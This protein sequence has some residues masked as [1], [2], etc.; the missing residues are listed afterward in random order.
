MYQVECCGF[1]RTGLH[2]GSGT[3]D[4]TQ[5]AF[6]RTAD[7]HVVV[8]GTSLAG[9]IRTHLT[10]LVPAM[11]ALESDGT[12]IICDALLA[13]PP[14]EDCKCIV[15]HLMGDINPQPIVRAKTGEAAGTRASRLTIS[16]GLVESHKTFV[17]DGVSIDRADGTAARA[18]MA[19]YDQEVLRNAQLC[20]SVSLEDA[21]DLDQMLVRLI[22][23]EMFAGRVYLGGSKGRGLGA[24]TL[25]SAR[26]TQLNLNDPAHLLHFL[27][28]DFPDSPEV[29][30][31]RA[32]GRTHHASYRRIIGASAQP[33]LS[34]S[35]WVRIDVPMKG[36]GFFMTNDQTRANLNGLNHYALPVLPGASIRGVL[37]SHAE[38][39]AR[40]IANQ[41]SADEDDFLSRLPAAYP[42][43]GQ[44]D[45]TADEQRRLVPLESTASRLQRDEGMSEADREAPEYEWFD[46]AERLFGT[47]YFGSRLMVEDAPLTIEAPPKVLDFL[48]VDRFTG[49]GADGAKFDALVYWQPEFTLSLYLE[50]PQPWEI[51]WLLV[52]LRDL[53][54]GRLR[55][56]FGSAKGFGA[57]NVLGTA[58]TLGWTYDA[59]FPIDDLR[60]IPQPHVEGYFYQATYDSFA[61]LPIELR[62]GWNAAWLE[63]VTNFTTTDVFTSAH[64]A[65]DPYW[66]RQSDGPALHEIYGVG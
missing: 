37:R 48:A 16:D 60:L 25:Q 59:A 42:Q 26:P 30:L 51:G 9:T 12:K 20:F 34:L 27:R 38:R 15:C 21:N 43:A 56:G 39:I 19:K 46:L 35:S 47:T 41:N 24:F 7:G 17:Q 2:I 40:T 44:R 5:R 1:F 6:R 62:R 52:V 50:T 8:P 36:T 13:N 49:G 55:F 3:E 11:T 65:N 28:E 33:D 57:V 10:R 58:V 54:D 31:P 32:L 66:G 29:R 23:D 63:T 61:A 22:L 14:T 18:Q 64:L 4:V 45:Q 53:I